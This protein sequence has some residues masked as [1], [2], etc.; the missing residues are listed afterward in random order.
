MAEVDP[1]SPFLRERQDALEHVKVCVCACTYRR[2]DG[3][4]AMLEGI[5]R[6]TFS[7]MPRPILYVVIAD[8]ECGDR[9]REVCASFEA[10]HGIPVT[11]VPEPKRGISFARNACLD[12][13]PEGFDFFA[14]IDDDEVPDPDWLEKLLEAQAATG[15]DVVQGAVVPIFPSGTPAWLV[16]GNFFGLP[17]RSWTGTALHRHE[18]QDLDFAATNNALVRVAAVNRL[19]LRFDPALALTGGEDSRFFRTLAAAGSRIVYAPRARVRE[20]VPA[21]RATAWYRLKLEFRI[22]YTRAA[23]REERKKRKPI[24]WLRQRWHDSGPEKVAS[25]FGLLLRNGVSG[26]LD[27]DQALVGG[28]RIAYGLGQFAHAVGITYTPYR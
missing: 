2:P 19:G 4:S 20:T 7:T 23:Q 6:Q 12:N 15:A 22:G 17:R 13:I 5:V 1:Q 16:D 14:S 18:H 11:Y 21:E 26:R 10:R 3:L 8:N 25:G 27:K 28:M 9:T 24:R